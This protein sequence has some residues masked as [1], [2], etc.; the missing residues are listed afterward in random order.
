MKENNTS[1]HSTQI[2][3]RDIRSSDQIEVGD[4]EESVTAIG[5]NAKAIVTHHVYNIINQL[6]RLFLGIIIGGIFSIVAIL[7]WFVFDDQL[8]WLFGEFSEMNSQT[9]NIAVVDFAEINSSGDVVSS[10]LT[11][12]MSEIF[13]EE[14]NQ[15]GFSDDEMIRIWHRSLP[16]LNRRQSQKLKSFNSN[17]PDGQCQEAQ[18]LASEVNA[19]I[20][21]YGNVDSRLK[22]GGFTLGFYIADPDFQRMLTGNQYIIQVQHEIEDIDYLDESNCY[23]VGEP[24][25]LDTGSLDAQDRY[26][27]IKHQTYFFFKL[28]SGLTENRL[29]HWQKAI[30]HFEDLDTY[31]ND[32][33]HPTERKQYG[34]DLINS[35]LGHQYIG[36]FRTQAH[37][38]KIPEF[39]RQC[40]PNDYFIKNR[41]IRTE[42]TQADLTLLDIGVEHFQK[43]IDTSGIH[44]YRAEAGLG[45]TW[46]TIGV[47]AQSKLVQAN[48][49]SN[50]VIN[51]SLDT[52]LEALLAQ[53]WN[54][55]NAIYEVL[56]K[57]RGH[58][59]VAKN[60][61]PNTNQIFFL[62]T[63]ISE[64]T[65]TQLEGQLFYIIDD[66]DQAISNLDK[67][68]QQFDSL[69][70]QAQQLQEHRHT[71]FIYQN[72]G[73]MYYQKT[74][75]P[76]SSQHQNFL[77][78]ANEYLQRCSN[79]REGNVG[80]DRVREISSNCSELLQSIGKA[81]S[82]G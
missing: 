12:D 32:N 3:S 43:A 31:L 69:L 54:K 37:S 21:I 48:D 27:A 40:N 82:Q 39:N 29:G 34:A 16:E 53:I 55:P 74:F 28:I 57:A 68:I 17:H 47:I 75:M 64:A 8:N 67:A 14:I 59:D 9:K 2:E 41:K 36:K 5:R 71:V 51:L 7:F 10:Q 4:I 65:I 72:L 62:D 44:Q 56:K 23:L 26:N 58:Y 6:S 22:G 52:C 1:T 49:K 11:R 80:D 42:E 20:V 73:Q 13:H 38:L 63:E 35:L 78:K 50:T 45:L 30:D 19:H 15:L 81:I 66:Y 25:L 18:K 76:D 77:D 70:T 24:I 46:L 60:I 33:L 61:A 79:Y